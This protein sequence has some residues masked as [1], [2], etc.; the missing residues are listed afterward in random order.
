MTGKPQD[1][2]LPISDETVEPDLRFD[3]D[4]ASPA[5]MYDYYL[6]G[7]DNYAADRAVADTMIA[8]H[9]V[10]LAGARG[11]RRFMVRAVEA[12]AQAGVRQFIDIGAG[13]PTSPNTHEVAQRSHPGARVVY[14]DND[15]VV[16][17][18]TRALRSAPG[19]VAIEGD[20]REPE[21]IL[22]DPQLTDHIDFSQPVGLL[23]V[24]V[25]H[26]IRHDEYPE[27]LVDRLVRPLVPGSHLVVS[28]GS[29]EGHSP[30]AVARFEA[31]YQKSSS[32][33][34]LHS[35][36]DVARWLSGFE[37]L[38]PGITS[39]FKWRADEEIP[40]DLSWLGAAGRLPQR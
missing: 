28:S 12:L 10:V 4:V 22:A 2:L 38:D 29:S 16:L 33:L 31:T 1:S 7:K 18:H 36:A 23:L 19:V 27:E 9:P 25:L 40:G 35:R 3:P 30:E 39:I 17:A 14:V 37:L 21:A 26:F 5:R 11:N 6:G 13:I 32:P 24:A 8:T 20:V 34:V 15:P